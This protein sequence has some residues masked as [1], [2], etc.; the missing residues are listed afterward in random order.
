M[1]VVGEVLEVDGRLLTVNERDPAHVAAMREF[2]I[3]LARSRVKS[4]YGEL[5]DAAELPYLARGL[6][7]LLNLLSEDCDR[8]NEP[9]LAALVVTKADSE[10]GDG[11]T[12]DAAGERAR[13]YAYWATR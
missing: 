7:R 4:T 11:Y 8:R 6:G 13:V 9:S 5:V 2:L 10:V 3:D 12:G 1:L